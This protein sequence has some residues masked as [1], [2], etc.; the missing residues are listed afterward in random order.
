MGRKKGKKGKKNR[1]NNNDNA[2]GSYNENEEKEE[3]ETSGQAVEENWDDEAQEHVESSWPS[4]LTQDETIGQDNSTTSSPQTT[5]H[6]ENETTD[7]ASA[8]FSQDQPTNNLQTQTKD[9]GKV[10]N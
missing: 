3:N 4:D 6:Q 9:N 5:S 7:S 1:R 2:G 8:A 10:S